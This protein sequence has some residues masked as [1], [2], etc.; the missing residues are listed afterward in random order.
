MLDQSWFRT[1]LKKDPCCV[2]TKSVIF[3]IEHTHR[4]MQD[5]TLLPIEFVLDAFS[6]Q[7]VMT[8]TDA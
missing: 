8:E 6:R 2:K 4:R 5:P 3:E 7:Q 1:S